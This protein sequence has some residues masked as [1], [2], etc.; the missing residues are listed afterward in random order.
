[1]LD[2]QMIE[3]GEIVTFNM[4]RKKIRSLR[5]SSIRYVIDFTLSEFFVTSHI[6]INS[7]LTELLLA[8]HPTYAV[9][10]SQLYGL[11]L[12]HLTNR[13]YLPIAT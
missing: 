1:M 6:Y 2:I 9:A 5:S 11:M 10:S 12:Q 4:N 7:Q 8:Q 13:L 3:F